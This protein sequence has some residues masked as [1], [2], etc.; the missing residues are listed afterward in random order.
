MGERAD[1]QKRLVKA[2][3]ILLD[4]CRWNHFTVDVLSVGGDYMNYIMLSGEA[5]HDD[6]FELL[7]LVVEHD[8]KV[9]LTEEG[10]RVWP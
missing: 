9:S 1:A 8:W 7:E 3:C 6:L 2:I 10:I 5:N 4:N